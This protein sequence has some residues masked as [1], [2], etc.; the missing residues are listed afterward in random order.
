[1]SSQKLFIPA[2]SVKQFYAMP[3]SPTLRLGQAF[4]DH[5]KLWKHHDKEFTNR[6][7]QADGKD[8]K[9]LIE[10]ITDFNQ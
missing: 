4:Y 9:E 6:L 2:S 5:F 7:Y 10:Q 1:M 8:A 3:K